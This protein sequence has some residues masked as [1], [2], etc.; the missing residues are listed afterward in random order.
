MVE[1]GKAI[2]SVIGTTMVVGALGNITKK[3]KKLIITKKTKKKNGNR[4]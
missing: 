1:Y 2:G 3:R 4:K